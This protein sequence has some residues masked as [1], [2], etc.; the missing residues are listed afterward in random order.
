MLRPAV[1]V[2]L[3]NI[4]SGRP[5]ATVIESALDSRSRKRGLLGRDRF[6]PGHALVIAPTNP[7]HTF[8]MRF[9][10]DIVFA[11]REGR[12]VKIR[13]DV[14]P[15]RIT[16]ALTGFAVIELAA[17]ELQRSDTRVGDVLKLV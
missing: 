7:V 10:I 2:T 8:S 1:A 14:P 4:R 3:R 9:N 12:V 17:G 16:G 11:N 15:R 5:V 6:P 13:T